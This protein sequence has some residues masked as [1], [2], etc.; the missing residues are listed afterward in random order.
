L[1]KNLQLLEKPMHKRLIKTIL[2]EFLPLL[3][4]STILFLPMFYSQIYLSARS[5]FVTHILWAQNIFAF[6]QKV[7]TYVYVHSGWQMMV[8]VLHGILGH[9]WNF[10]ALIVTLG[11]ELFT[12]GILYWLLRKKLN[13]WLAGALALG[14]NI[15]APLLFLYPIDHQ[16]YY[17]YIYFNP[18]HNPTLLLLKPF[19]ILVIVFTVQA[20]EG[21]YA[22]WQ[23]ILLAAVVSV[24]GAFAKPNYVLCLLPA[25]GILAL[26]RLWK[27]K[28]VDW[29]Q[30]ILGITLPPVL[31]IL[32]QFILT[33]TSAGSDNSHILFAPFAVMHKLSGY[34]LI[35]LLLSI[36]FPLVVAIIYRKEIFKDTKMQLAWLGFG[37]GAFFAYFMAESGIRFS[38]GNFLWSAEISLFILYI[39]SVLFL[40]EKGLPLN[41]QSSKWILLGIG[42]LNIVFGVL[43][44]A[45]LLVNP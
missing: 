11:S 40:T 21:K 18:Y 45:F 42:C 33:Y 37:F 44:F 29:K 7:P 9:S 25:A 28:A 13:P 34:L 6:P 4:V 1:Q 14:L 41:R 24:I 26:I 19:A 32:W 39:C 36:L 23:K 31:L 16:T 2:V 35:K 43:Y 30:L 22:S 8:A 5:D 17:G 15:I 20:L 38:D 10:S 27:K 3:V 12:V